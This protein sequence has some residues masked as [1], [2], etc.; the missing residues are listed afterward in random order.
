MDTI[1]KINK[2]L[3]ENGMTGA[4]LSRQIGVSTGVYSQWNTRKT[5]PSSRKLKQIAEVFGVNPFELLPDKETGED[6]VQTAPTP[7]SEDDIKFALF[8]TDEITDDLYEEVKR[9][10]KYAMEQEK[11]RKFRNAQKGE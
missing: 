6:A 1:D 5:K 11:F 10:A 2:L 8:G 9:Y 3:A 4:E 7:V